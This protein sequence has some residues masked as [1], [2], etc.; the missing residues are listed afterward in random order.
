MK[1]V[2][3]TIHV[4]GMTCAACSAAIERKL[5]KTEGVSSVAVSLVTNSASITYDSDSITL[6]QIMGIIKKLGYEPSRQNQKVV[7]EE[8]GNKQLWLALVL[9][10]TLFSV[11][12]FPMIGVPF[13][14]FLS[15]DVSP[16]PYAVVQIILLLPI[17]YLG[18]HFFVSGFK[19]LIGGAPNMDSLIAISTSSAFAFSMYSFIQ[20]LQGD[21]HAVHNLYFESAG[22]IIVLI[23]LGKSLEHSSKNRAAGAIKKL[24][25]MAP[26]H[27]T[28]IA[29]DGSEMNVPIEKIV[30][31]DVVRVRPGEKIPVDGT[32]MEGVSSVDES[33]LTGESI[34]VEKHVGD[35]VYAAC[36]NNSGL[37]LIQTTRTG[38]D[39]ALAQIIRLVE[40]AQLSK[41]PISRLA[42]KISGIFV[43]SVISI[44]LFSALLWMFAGKDIAFAITIFV[45]VLVIACP[46]ALGLATPTAILV[47]T[48]R[49]A[50]LGILIK[51][52]EPL[53]AT[54]KIKVLLLDKT[55]T[56]TKGEPEVTDFV[57][58][59]KEPK[60]LRLVGV[61]EKL[62][63]HPLATAIARYAETAE[64]SAAPTSYEEIP[65]HGIVT[66]IEGHT[67]L[68]GNHK[69]L[70]RYGVPTDSLESYFQTFSHE[71]KTSILV[72]LD[73]AAAGIV[74][75]ADTI[76]E[77]AVE[78]I[79]KLKE[80]GVL[81]VMVT[82]DNEVTAR[83]IAA[84]VG[85][86]EVIAGVLPEGK[87]EAIARYR[88]YGVVGMV[89][90]GINDAP[91]LV[92]ADV[93]IAIGSGTDIAIEAADIVLVRN[94][95]YDVCRA[96][97]LSKKTIVNI[98]ENLFWAFIYN[99][100]GIPVAAG[101]LYA[102]G[103]PLMNPML[104]AAAMSLSSVSVVSNA[105]RLKHFQK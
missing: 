10:F 33:M 102:F 77:N 8:K 61:A 71:G 1:Q 87:S 36:I 66:E 74:A 37:L 11:A 19:H 26:K 20:V 31:G 76:K 38:D 81:P 59:V 94:D 79:A 62:S 44:G 90:D 86:D 63:V 18:K 97:E 93:G 88:S 51:G 24:I 73:G 4:G 60:L 70:Q 45:S 49:G 89:G 50:E 30:A 58:I 64:L 103:G 53:E 91:A 12:M 47:G 2:E 52:G 55:G 22:I 101:L 23:M 27:A 48:G 14:D 29:K 34:G 92:S 6:T 46:C 68:V 5:N 83:A 104:A 35:P 54:H 96:I 98:K 13:P 57:N 39:T 67:L 69:L 25:Q 17:M 105:L 15:P 99:T 72:A 41:A 95:I 9:G 80:M 82:G 32:V 100:I 84:Q 56:I 16:I 85:I 65:G 75:V 28:V 3:S 43:P 7:E 42:D 40:E 78:A 21:S